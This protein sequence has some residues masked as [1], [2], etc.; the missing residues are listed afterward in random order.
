[1]SSNSGA[2][3]TMGDGVVYFLENDDGRLWKYDY[4]LDTS[5]GNNTNEFVLTSDSFNSSSNTDG[6]GC[7]TA[8]IEPP[9][10]DLVVSDPYQG[11]CSNGEADVRVDLTAYQTTMW[12]DLSR[13]VDLNDGNGFSSWVAT[14]DG[15]S[16]N[17]GLSLIHI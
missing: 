14:I 13:R 11:S 3:M 5:T 12:Y 10:G 7:G 1:M 16:L 9:A 15:G 17:A 8:P 2:A 6:A 4:S